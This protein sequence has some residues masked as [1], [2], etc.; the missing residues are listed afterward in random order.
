MKQPR[1]LPLNFPILPF[2]YIFLVDGEKGGIGKSTFARVIAQWLLDQ[3]LPVIGIDCDRSNE[4]FEDYCKN[5]LPIHKAF[6]TEDK[7]QAWQADHLLETPLKY[8]AHIAADLPAQTQKAQLEYF[9]K[10]GIRAAKRCKIQFIKFFLCADFYS[11]EQFIESLTSFG[12]D[13]PHILVLNDGL[14]DDFSFLDDHQQ[15]NAL[16][17]ENHV[18]V[19]RMPEIPYRE[20]EIINTFR[21]SYAEALESEHMTITGQQRLTDYMMDC[22]EQL[23]QL[24]LFENAK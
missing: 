4:S 22:Y 21:L 2:Y 3:D 10:G 17:E 14:C 8:K 5:I 7:K 12:S 13:I 23:D 16:L 9:L 20:K 19:L 6:F 18:P 15:L 24:G 1:I 11:T